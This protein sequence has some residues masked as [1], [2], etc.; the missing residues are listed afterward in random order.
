MFKCI[1]IGSSDAPQLFVMND[2]DVQCYS[3][4]HLFWLFVVGLPAIFIYFA[5]PVLVLIYVAKNNVKFSSDETMMKYHF[6]FKRYAKKAIYW[7]LIIM[8]RSGFFI[9]CLTYLDSLY[10]QIF[11]AYA[12]F[13]IMLYVHSRVHPYFDERL[14]K[15]EQAS[16]AANCAL[17]FSGIYFMQDT[18]ISIGYI[19]VNIVLVV[20]NANY[21]L[22]QLILLFRMYKDQF[23][24]MK[25]KFV[26][27]RNRRIATLNAKKAKQFA[28]KHGKVAPNPTIP[29]LNEATDRPVDGPEIPSP[30]PLELAGSPTPYSPVPEG[31]E[32]PVIT[33]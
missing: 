32:T 17:L 26:E 7:D 3:S 16:L 33:P 21:W 24:K 18:T 27:R 23:E 28:L 2:Y 15:L 25:E 20:F 6:V 31:F 5:G 30:L 9:I 13:T 1:D 10:S 12:L 29:G 4:D 22:R 8:L 14:N 19:L 11:L